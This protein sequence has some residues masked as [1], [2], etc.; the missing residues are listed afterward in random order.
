MDDVATAREG[1]TGD[2]HPSYST[3]NLIIIKAYD[4]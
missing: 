2:T 3:M 4:M 1:G